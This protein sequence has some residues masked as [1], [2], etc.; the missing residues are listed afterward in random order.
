MNR[1]KRDQDAQEKKQNQS[2]VDFV[3]RMKADPERLRT[4]PPNLKAGNIDGRLLNLWHLLYVSSPSET[5]Y[6]IDDFGELAHILGPD[7]TLETRAALIRFWRGH[8]PTLT[9]SRAPDMRNLTSRADSMG[10]AGI[11][12]EAK[13]N[14]AWAEGLSSDEATIA[15][16]LATQE[17]NG[18]PHWT[19]QLAAA[20]PEEVRQVFLGEI[21]DHLVVTPGQHG[22]VDKIAYGDPALAALVAPSLV[23]HIEDHPELAEPE[24]SKIIDIVGRSLPVMRDLD[25]LEVL[26]LERFH[27]ATSENAAVLYLGIAFRVD[28]TAAIEALNKKLNEL[29]FPGQKRLA[30]R[31]LPRVFGDRMFRTGIDPKIL[32]FDVLER[33]VSMSFRTIRLEDDNVH[34]GSYTPDDRD[35][36]ES[37]RSSLFNQLLATPGRRTLDALKRFASDPGFSISPERLRAMILKRASEDAEHAPW[38]ASEALAMEKEFDTAP[39]TPRDLQLV[40]L[41]RIADIDHSLHHDEFAQGQTVKALP[42]ER[43]AQKW[44]ASELKNRKGRAYTLTR[45]SHVANEKEPDI[46]FQSNATDASMPIEIKIAESWTL[47]QLEHALTGQLAGRYLREKDKRHGVLLLVHQKTRHRGW[48]A[49]QGGY[50]TFGEVVDHLKDKARE[51]ESAGIDASRAEIAVIDVSDIAGGPVVKRKASKRRATKNP[52]QQA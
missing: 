38:P 31:A 32:P 7:L 29:D 45:E 9:S 16:Q 42:N 25:E 24:L 26:A 51:M 36:A 6:A 28:P 13:A 17:L 5:E 20:R 14:P 3:D 4:P 40:A 8:K 43:E 30:E 11:S 44:V 49:G 10:I 18:F 12:L 46:R 21:N 27:A 2:W 48:R 34:G 33:L 35:S 22:F 37:A 1:L 19:R 39:R 47:P 15:A 41:R 52:T 50:L 23:K